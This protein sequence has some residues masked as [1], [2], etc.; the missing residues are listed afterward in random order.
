MTKIPFFRLQTVI[1]FGDASMRHLSSI[2]ES[3]GVPIILCGTIIWGLT[4]TQIKHM[5]LFL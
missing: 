5:Y 3:T 1:G 4:K 2:P